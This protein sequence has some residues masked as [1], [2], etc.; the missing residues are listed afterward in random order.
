M[1][2]EAAK[3]TN[4]APLRLPRRAIATAV[5]TAVVTSA[6]SLHEAERHLRDK[7][8]LVLQTGHTFGVDPLTHG[9]IKKPSRALAQAVRETVMWFQNHL[10]EEVTS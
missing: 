7:E 2:I 5:S 9:P 4:G 8:L 1:T 10:H 6:L 3:R